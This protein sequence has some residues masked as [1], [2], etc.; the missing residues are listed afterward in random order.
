MRSDY[1]LNSLTWQEFEKLVIFIC[2]EIL[3][4]GSSTF[5]EGT[6]GGRDSRFHGTSQKFPS[7]V[8]SWSG[9]FI[10]QAKHTSNDNA[11]C[12][13]TDFSSISNKSSILVKE[14]KKLKELL[15]TEKFNNYILFTNRKL[16][17][18]TNTTITQWLQQE[19]GIENISIKGKEDITTFLDSYPDIAE[20]MGI[21][22]I[23]TPKIQF[24][25][26]DIRDVILM[27]NEE[28][29]PINQIL[30]EEKQ[31]DDSLVY[32]DKSKKNTLN[33]LSEE[34]FERSI[35][36]DSLQY[37]NKID[38]FLKD[39]KNKKY[40]N[41]Y[42]NTIKDLKNEIILKR[43]KFEKFE[44]ILEYLYKKIQSKHSEDLNQ[45]R[46]LIRVFLHYMYWNCDI[47][48]KQ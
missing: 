30:K 35:V 11:S 15:K 27:F 42:N 23:D 21:K 1:R 8:N 28:K 2:H 12:S 25:E 44:E 47:G 6:D 4:I 7:T 20:K 38:D 18:E 43:S 41:S 40:L 39:L 29:D 45:H 14:V 16:S 22:D 26:K 36:E 37:F 32:I 48:K 24:Y 13:D 3:G 17:G 10:I 33:N 9:L 46:N 5:S 31:E 34:Y 19:L